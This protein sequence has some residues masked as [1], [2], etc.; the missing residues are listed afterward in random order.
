M[1]EQRVFSIISSLSCLP[2]R[3]TAERVNSQ[4]ASNIII[5]D[6]SYL[7]KQRTN[8][9]RS[10]HV[11]EKNARVWALDNHQSTPMS[12]GLIFGLSLHGTIASHPQLE[13][14]R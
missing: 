11:F 2:I 4:S 1:G 8:E 10:I 9:R 13:L 7:P 12:S 6:I 5:F 14:L 3:R